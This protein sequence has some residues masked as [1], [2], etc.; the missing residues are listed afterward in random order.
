MIHN[1][2]RFFQYI[3]ETTEEGFYRISLTLSRGFFFY[4]YIFF[5]FL[6]KV[7]HWRGFTRIKEYFRMK[8]N[9]ST[10]F[11]TLVLVFVVGV[12]LHTY[13]YVDKNDVRY[14]DDSILDIVQTRVKEDGV[15]S[16]SD[17]FQ[18]ILNSHETNLFRKFGKASINSLDYNE[19][20]KINSDF[21]LWM[22]VDG[23]NIN[24]PIVQTDDNDYYLNHDYMGNI[25]ASGWTYVDFRNHSDMSDQ[26][27]IFYGHNLLNKTGFGSLE[28]IFTEKWLKYSNHYI[29]VANDERKYIYQVFSCY[30]V[31]PEIYYLQTNF[32]RNEDYQEFIDTLLDRSIYDFQLDVDSHDKIITLSTCTDDSK[33][34]RVVH[35]KLIA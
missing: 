5:S 35:A 7:F 18:E 4:F 9:D 33:G 28:N 25:K 30:T 29:V 21:V 27:T 26:N 15:K 31:E 13:L 10:A 24:Y 3:I 14:V 34:R 12:F 23:T 16:N 22:M 1:F 20:K 6:E 32:Y 19:L 8:Q 11:L 17:Y 2:K